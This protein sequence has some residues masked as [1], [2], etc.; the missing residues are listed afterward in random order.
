ML[1]TVSVVGLGVMEV[2][3]LLGELRCPVGRLGVGPDKVGEPVGESA[4]GEVPVA[5]A[6]ADPSGCTDAAAEAAECDGGDPLHAAVSAAKAAIYISRHR[7]LRCDRSLILSSADRRE[8]SAFNVPTLP[9][10]KGTIFH[11]I[12][13]CHKSSPDLGEDA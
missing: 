8:S 7:F 13:D 12:Y 11:A 5:F 1:G 9:P 3:E 6:E 4:F 2:A 10:M